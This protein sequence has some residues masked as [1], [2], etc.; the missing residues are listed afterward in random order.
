MH[1]D[2][3]DVPASDFDFAGVEAR[4]QRQADLP[5]RGAERQR[6][7][8]RARRPV[9]SRENA[10]A[11]RLDQRAAVLFD[12]LFGQLIVAVQQSAPRMVAIFGGAAGRIDDVGK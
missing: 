11:G 8:H 12:R 1:R 4:A 5:C 6:A 9:E 2:A 3:A 10:V 7:A